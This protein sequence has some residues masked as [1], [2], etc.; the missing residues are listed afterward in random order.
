MRESEVSFKN[1]HI[2]QSFHFAYKTNI[3]ILGSTLLP[4]YRLISD[5]GTMIN[6]PMDYGDYSLFICEF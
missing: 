6:N 1:A 5:R 3:V 4:A 2:S